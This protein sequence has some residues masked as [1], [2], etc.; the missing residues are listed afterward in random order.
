MRRA[1]APLSSSAG[2]AT[3]TTFRGY[4]GTT[5]EFRCLGDCSFSCYHLAM[6]Q[7]FLLPEFMKVRFRAFNLTLPPQQVVAGCLAGASSSLSIVTKGGK[8][9]VA[10]PS[11]AGA[12]GASAGSV[13][14]STWPVVGNPKPVPP[15]LF[16]ANSK[17]VADCDYQRVMS[18]DLSVCFEA[19]CLSLQH[20]FEKW[21]PQAYFTGIVINGST[22]TGGRIEGPSLDSFAGAVPGLP[23]LSQWG[24]TLLDGVVAGFAS[25]WSDYAR[26]V[27]VPGL[28]WYPAFAVWTAGASTP[29]MP[30]VPCPF[31]GL[32]SQDALISSNGLDMTMRA[33]GAMNTPYQV[34]VYTAVA[35]VLGS[36]LQ[37]WRASQIVQNVM[38]MGQVPTWNPPYVCAGPVVGGTVLPNPGCLSS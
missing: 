17:A 29:P 33:K 1:G 34:E 23:A 15:A 19:I 35:D 3:T 20:V 36:A 32:G 26:T 38:G 30:N 22:A 9:F 2:P 11:T 6:P 16:R 12:K 28:P 24:K 18:D 7:L 8:A 21:R 14:S 10:A 4:R 5:G 31:I 27:Y 13:S 25:A 37:I